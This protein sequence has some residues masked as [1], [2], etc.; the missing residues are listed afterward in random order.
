MSALLLLDVFLFIFG[1]DTENISEFT[2]IDA[3][4]RILYSA[5]R[6]GADNYI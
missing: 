1:G 4:R 2:F 3:G 5:A 6:R